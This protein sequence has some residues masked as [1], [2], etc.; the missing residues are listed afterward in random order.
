M[1]S[2]ADLGSAL[3]VCAQLPGRELGAVLLSGSLAS[4]YLPPP[5]IPTNP[6]YL[7]EIRYASL[8]SISPTVQQASSHLPL[9]PP[10]LESL[11]EIPKCQGGVQ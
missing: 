6:P 5:P 1:R 10:C 11:Q 4:N 3:L 7:V 8:L 2:L 9:P